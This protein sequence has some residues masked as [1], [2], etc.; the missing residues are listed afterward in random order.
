MNIPLE[1]AYEADDRK[2][3]KT[4]KHALSRV[5]KRQPINVTL[6]SCGWKVGIPKTYKNN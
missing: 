3:C 1:S 6:D 5:N 4:V 2:Q